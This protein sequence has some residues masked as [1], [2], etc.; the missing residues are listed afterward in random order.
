MQKLRFKTES[1]KYAE[2][3]AICKISK[4]ETGVTYIPESVSL[5]YEL[6]EEKETLHNNDGRTDIAIITSDGKVYLSKDDIKTKV[7]EEPLPPKETR[8]IFT[9]N[10][11]ELQS[12]FFLYGNLSM[13]TEN[14]EA[15][16]N[17]TNPSLRTKLEEDGHE[18]QALYHIRKKD[19]PEEIITQIPE[20]Y[21]GTERG[22]LSKIFG[23]S[24][25]VTIICVEKDDSK[26]ELYA[27]W[28][29][30]HSGYTSKKVAEGEEVPDYF[31]EIQ[32]NSAINPYP[33][34]ELPIQ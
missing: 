11:R 4:D 6:K 20:T 1:G 22:I 25:Q 2:P 19:L 32:A 14:L 23:E 12:E 10:K 9:E 33:L 17:Y 24:P 27:E 18:P 34:D 21:E 30:E 8:D 31:K 26:K 3:L 7:L 13:V 29:D 5:V 15:L 16:N 28:Y